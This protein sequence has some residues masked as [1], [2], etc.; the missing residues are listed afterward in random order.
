MWFQINLLMAIWVHTAL[1]QF[2][3]VA[4]AEHWILIVYHITYRHQD[5]WLK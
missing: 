4:K 5:K 1:W 2:G 3:H